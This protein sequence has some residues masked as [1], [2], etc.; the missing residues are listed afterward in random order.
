VEKANEAMAIETLLVTDELFRYNA[1]F[2]GMYCV[3][4]LISGTAK[5]K[6]LQNT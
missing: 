1:N 5:E 3:V 4:A 6:I 2:A